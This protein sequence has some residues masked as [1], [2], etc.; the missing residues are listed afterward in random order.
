[1]KMNS[2]TIKELVTIPGVGKTV[3]NDL[4]NIGISCIDDLK[5]KKPEQ[6]YDRSNRFVGRIQDR[7]LLYIFRSA[8]YYA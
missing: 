4:V 5:G 6:F 7:C 1:M 3:A 8:V 2:K